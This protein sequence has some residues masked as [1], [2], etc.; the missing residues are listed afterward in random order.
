M[1]QWIVKYH[2]LAL[3]D[4]MKLDNSQR[5]LV[6][7]AIKKVSTNSLPGYRGGYGKPL[8]NHKESKL[9]GY[10]KI[11]VKN[12]GLR[13]IYKL[14]QKDQNMCILVIGCRSNSEVYKIAQKRK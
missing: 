10:L 12:E 8:K 13:V 2:K 7:K 5:K 14:V 4:M 6:L 1:N 9:A 3:K 11:T